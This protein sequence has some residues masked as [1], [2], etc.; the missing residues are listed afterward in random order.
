MRLIS[1]I[2]VA[3]MLVNASPTARRAEAAKS[4]SATGARSPIDI[5]SP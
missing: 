2:C 4:S 5:A 3:A 1:P